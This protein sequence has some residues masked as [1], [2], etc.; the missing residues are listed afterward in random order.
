MNNYKSVLKGAIIG[1]LAALG[2]VFLAALILYMTNATT[3]FVGITSKLIMVVSAFLA[4]YVTG[5]QSTKRR[6]LWGMISGICVYVLVELIT[7]MAGS[8]SGFTTGDLIG[9]LIYAIIA[10]IGGMLS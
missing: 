5:K 1:F 10:S 7:I 3:I 6:F 2:G 4:G 9:V 8:F